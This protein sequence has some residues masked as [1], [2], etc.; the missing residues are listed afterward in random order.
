MSQPSTE[1]LPLRIVVSGGI[2]SGKSTVT[3][4]LRELGAVVIE[5]DTLGHEVLEP[6]G[7]AFTDVASR[8]PGVVVAGTISRPALAEIV[9]SDPDQLRELEAMTHPAIAA[10]IAHRV[11]AAGTSPI[12]LELPVHLDLVGPEWIRVVLEA[13]E[14]AR[15]GRAIGRGAE[16]ADIRRRMAAQASPEEWRRTAD[17]VIRNDGTRADLVAAVDALWENLLRAF[18]VEV[19]TGHR[20]PGTGASTVEP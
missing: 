13:D 18:G 4:R 15:V 2:G 11:D 9:F 20:T 3:A 6:G 17:H 1:S 8:W 12:V 16:E 14:D 10:E 7:A 5:A 19:D